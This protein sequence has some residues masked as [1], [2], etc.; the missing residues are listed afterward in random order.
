LRGEVLDLAARRTECAGAGP[1]QAQDGRL[2]VALE[3]HVAA[4]YGAQFPTL[5][6][7]A[8][9]QSERGFGRRIDKETGW[10]SGFMP[11]VPSS[12]ASSCKAAMRFSVDG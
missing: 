6:V 7:F 12:S 11:A 10:D 2:L 9:F 3:H 5:I 1:R 4:L 8:D